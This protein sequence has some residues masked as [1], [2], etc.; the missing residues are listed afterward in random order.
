MGDKM[1]KKGEKLRKTKVKLTP[2]QIEAKQLKKDFNR[3]YFFFK[4]LK[5]I[6][7]MAC[8][9]FKKAK[10]VLRKGDVSKAKQMIAKYTVLDINNWKKNIEK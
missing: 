1:I 10:S 7:N 2:K 4:A 6:G 8:K 3:Q 9:D 5:K